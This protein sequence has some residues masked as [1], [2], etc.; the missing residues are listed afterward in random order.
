M[1]YG[2]VQT[3]VVKGGT[4]FRWVTRHNDSIQIAHVNNEDQADLKPLRLSDWS[5]LPIGTLTYSTS[6]QMTDQQE[7]EP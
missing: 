2:R 5:A 7:L 3:V 6:G 4:L 1:K